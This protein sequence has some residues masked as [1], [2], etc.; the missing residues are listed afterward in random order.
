MKKVT[1]TAPGKV[2]FSGEH[3]VVFGKRAISGAIKARIKVQATTE[4]HHYLKIQL[5]NLKNPKETDLFFSVPLEELELILKDL[6]EPLKSDVIYK[7]IEKLIDELVDHESCYLQIL[8]SVSF[9]YLQILSNGGN[10]RG[11]G[12]FM[13]VISTDL[14]I[15]CGLGSSASLNV[16]TAASFLVLSDLIRPIKSQNDF[17]FEEKSL[18]LINDVSFQMEKFFHGNPSGVDNS[19]CTYGG[20]LSYK[21]GIITHLPKYFLL[22]NIL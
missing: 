13:K 3:S 14:P 21:C 10:F 11:G 22:N 1:V 19:T 5:P 4:K 17:Y 8:Y 15:G 6:N 12:V 7:K 18:N 16:A 2:I 20:A 9:L